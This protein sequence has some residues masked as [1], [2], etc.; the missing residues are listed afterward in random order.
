MNGRDFVDFK[1][2]PAVASAFFGRD[3]DRREIDV[4]LKSY[5]TENDRMY[6]YK[7]CCDLLKNDGQK[8]FYKP[9]MFEDENDSDRQEEED[10]N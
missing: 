6:D 1:A 3:V 2:F 4:G 9:P 7:K 8:L 5:D 10:E